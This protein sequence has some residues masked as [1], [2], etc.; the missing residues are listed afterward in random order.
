MARNKYPEETVQ[1]ILDVSLSLFMEKG[2]AHTSIQD[3]I[4][5]LGGLSKGAIY[6]HFKSKEAILLAVYDR[7]ALQAGREMK[8]IVHDSSLNGAQKLKGMFLSSWKDSTQREFIAS[9]PNL[10]NNPQ[11]LTMHI[12]NT[13][14]DVVPHYILPVIE[15]GV[16]DGSIHC[17]YPQEMADVLMLLTNVWLNPLIYP[18]D[19]GNIWRKIRFFN[20]IL[21]GL[22]FPLLEEGMGEHM[23]LV[24]QKKRT[25]EP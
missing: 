8:E 3:I 17:E 7:M 4:N 11:F 9:M 14:H 25:F 20:E 2:Y 16:T 22:G 6:H 23:Q 15:E 10:L 13:I 21:S 18:M 5:N 12:A 24:E 19:E 1:K